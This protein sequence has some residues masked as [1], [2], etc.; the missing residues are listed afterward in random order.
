MAVISVTSIVNIESALGRELTATEE[1]RATYYI[2]AISAYIASYCDL[3]SFEEVPDDTI[4]AQ[5]DYYGI[6]DL[7]G[8]PISEVASVTSVDGTEVGG[9]TFDGTSRISGLGPFQ[10]VNIT[11]SHGT[12]VIPEDL[13]GVATEA[14]LAATLLTTP[15][16]LVRRTVGDVTDA[17]EAAG[18]VSVSLSAHVLNQYRTTDYTMRL[19]Q[20]W[21]EPDRPVN[22]FQIGG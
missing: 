10:T 19:G 20:S 15:V 3:I 18:G 11:Y 5:A 2:K 6:V 16:R 14:V 4:K 21:G 22:W 7:G 13:E 12:T 1:T 9:W 17:Y 8:D